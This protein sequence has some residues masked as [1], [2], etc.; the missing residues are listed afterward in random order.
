MNQSERNKSNFPGTNGLLQLIKSAPIWDRFFTNA[1]LILIGVCG[2]DTKEGVA[3]Q[4]MA[5][6]TGWQNYIGFEPAAKTGTAIALVQKLCSQFALN[7]L[8]RNSRVELNRIHDELRF[9]QP[10]ST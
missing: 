10:G 8:R 3:P 1:P 4:H 7:L 9:P 5:G 2:C 6:P